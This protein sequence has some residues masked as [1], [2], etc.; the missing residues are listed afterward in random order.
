MGK[1]EGF[2]KLRNDM[3]G[4]GMFKTTHHRARLV[5]KATCSWDGAGFDSVV[6]ERSVF[7]EVRAHH[8]YT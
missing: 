7:F 3:R 5:L 4:D 6:G 8:R 2:G 1:R